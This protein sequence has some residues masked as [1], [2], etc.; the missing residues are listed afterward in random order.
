[1]R[2]LLLAACL[3]LGFAP[4]QC[5]SGDPEDAPSETPPEALYQ[6]SEHFQKQ[7]DEK[8]RVETLEYLIDRYPNSRFAVRAKNELARGQK[9]P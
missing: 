8:A 6:L 2:A 9:A 7:G 1:M 3:S 4:L 5:G